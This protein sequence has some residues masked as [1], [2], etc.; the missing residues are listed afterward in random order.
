MIK[1]ISFDLDVSVSNI[2]IGTIK[3]FNTN[4]VQFKIN[5]VDN[6]RPFAMNDVTYAMISILLPNGTKSNSM[7]QVEGNTVSYNLEQNAVSQIGS[8]EAELQ[9]FATGNVML[10][11]STFHYFIQESLYSDGAVTEQPEYP[12]LIKLISDV[13]AM[14]ARIKPV[15][16]NEAARQQN[17]LT[18]ISN[19]SSRNSTFSG[20]VSAE[21][22]RISNENAR[23]S[24]ENTRQSNETIRSQFVF[25]GEYSPTTHYLKNNVVRYNGSSYACLV[26]S[27][28][29][30]PTNTSYWELV[31]LKGSDGLGVG[32]MLKATYDSNGSGIVDNSEKLGGQLPSYYAQKSEVDS[33]LNKDGSVPMTG[34]LKFNKG[35]FSRTYKEVLH[36]DNITN[37]ITGIL[38]IV[39]P[40]SWS[41]TMISGKIR[42][43]E[44]VDGKSWELDFAG[45]NPD[46]PQ[47]MRTTAKVNGE[48]PFSKVRFAH[49]GSKCCILL[50][51]L[52]T[53]WHYPSISITDFLTTYLDIDGW[54][55]GWSASIIASEAGITNI[56]EAELKGT[57]PKETVITTGLP[58]NFGGQIRY[59]K[60]QENEC[61]VLV[62]LNL[63]TQFPSGTTTI[64]TLPV[65]SR[66]KAEV[67][68]I[69]VKVTLKMGDGVE[70]PN[71][72]GRISID[73]NGII[74]L[75]T[76]GT[77]E[78]ARYLNCSLRFLT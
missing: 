13:T 51:D 21:N 63:A 4:S 72:Y 49:D 14:E 16:E 30:L 45:Y 1:Q 76:S 69:E 36:F 44:Y 20:M 61:E 59:Y 23:I 6:G 17:E 2:N 15:D 77:L 19:E 66:P 75:I 58:A 9:L 41:S 50:G 53:M 54:E 22:T 67:F 12:I 52:T 33:K 24:S 48:C 38:K 5:V 39:L 8:Y 28:E 35:T 25:S 37:D 57:V 46:I 32:D 47:W 71:S 65:G 7:A 18:R 55:S 26:D 34:A 43:F 78:N 11:S 68:E 40:K 73:P 42:G 62:Q 10:V 64:F 70:A 3:Q 56:V 60:T 31:A 74:K 29:H 27:F